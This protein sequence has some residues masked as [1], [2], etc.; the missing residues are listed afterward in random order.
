M[1]SKAI[2]ATHEGFLTGTIMDNI[3]HVSH[4]HNN[5]AAFFA[6]LFLCFSLGQDV[7]LFVRAQFL[8]CF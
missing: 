2:Q 6:F 4:L 5:K 3:P 1:F 8:L 7:R